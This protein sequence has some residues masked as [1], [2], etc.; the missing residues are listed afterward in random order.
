VN[1]C[2]VAV[3][4]AISSTCILNAAS[5]TFGK[6]PS[7]LTQKTQGLAAFVVFSLL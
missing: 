2:E 7:M 6:C 1:A 5:T 3:L 4:L